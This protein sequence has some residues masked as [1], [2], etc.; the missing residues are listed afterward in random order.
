VEGLK[1]GRIVYLVLSTQMVIEILRRRTTGDSIKDRLVKSEWPEGA[2]AHVGNLVQ[3]GEAVPAIVTCVHVPSPSFGNA[4][5]CKAFLDG[6]DEYWAR[7][8]P[9][10]ADGKDG[11]WHWMFPGQDTRYDATKP[12]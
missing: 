8:V 4:I 12:H 6:S 11:T 2:Q 7:N 5:N 1:T 9:Y 10:D 3:A